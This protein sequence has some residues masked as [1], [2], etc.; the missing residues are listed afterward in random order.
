MA[1]AESDAEFIVTYDIDFA[2]VSGR[3]CAPNLDGFSE[4]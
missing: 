4:L 3:P 2:P 1:V